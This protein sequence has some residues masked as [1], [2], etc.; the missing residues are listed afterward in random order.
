METIRPFSPADPLGT[1]LAYLD[2]LNLPCHVALNLVEGQP[3]LAARR[4]A[5]LEDAVDLARTVIA[6]LQD[7]IADEHAATARRLQIPSDTKLRYA[8]FTVL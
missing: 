8:L 1:A 4:D 3:E 6:F 5:I 2:L 7:D